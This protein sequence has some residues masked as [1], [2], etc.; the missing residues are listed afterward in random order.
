[1]AGIENF[2]SGFEG[3]SMAIKIINSWHEGWKGD[4][5]ITEEQTIDYDLI[6]SQ[7][8]QIEVKSTMQENSFRRNKF[9][10]HSKGQR[11]NLIF[12]MLLSPIGNKVLAYKLIK[13]KQDK[14]LVIFE[15]SLL[16]LDILKFYLEQ[17]NLLE[18][19]R[20]ETN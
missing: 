4:F 18:N 8:V 15:N 10:L 11:N 1:M 19:Y 13:I 7:G 16:G 12:F 20:Q 6:N 14:P 2:S 5:K 9:S 3:E 17:D